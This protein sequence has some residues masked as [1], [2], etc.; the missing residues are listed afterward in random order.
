MKTSFVS[1]RS[2][3]ILG[4]AAL[5]AAGLLPSLPLVAAAPAALP[6]QFTSL[7]T[8]A[9][10]IAYLQNNLGKLSA[11]QQIQIAAAIIQS[12]PAN[13][14]KAV[15]TQ[16]AHLLAPKGTD[17]VKVATQLVKALPA[18]L[19]ASLAG[20]IA[21]GASQAEPSLI[22]LVTAAV[23]QATPATIANAPAIAA[24]VVSGSPIESS[25]AVAS[26]IGATFYDNKAL[27][28]EAPQI[29]ASMVGAL[30]QLGT[31]DQVKTPV[32]QTVAALTALLPGTISEN[33]ALITQ[34]GKEVAA[35]IS[36]HYPSLAPAIVGVTTETLK[37]AAGGSNVNPVL[38]S[39]AD[40]F[41]NAIGDTGIKE[42]IAT[43]LLAV[44]QGTSNI[45]IS[46][47]EKTIGN[48]MKDS[49]NPS[50]LPGASTDGSKVPQ[51]GSYF[52][53]APQPTPTPTPNVGPTNP[54]ETPVTNR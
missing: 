26:A 2:A 25:V 28:A 8:V 46:G 6:A 19:G 44:Q 13:Q 14:Q 38:T 45:D 41:A 47:L 22:G 5:L 12:A 31:I 3:R 34:I 29:A 51:P 50:V 49:G 7:R 23:I 4:A 54:Q 48:A 24:A 53:W 11:A 21:L 36:A 32:A 33:S 30:V 10:K 37:T 16:L 35:T 40:A 1:L 39:F 18:N 52:F 20:S 9:E 27:A 42:Q 15:A 17:P 43:T